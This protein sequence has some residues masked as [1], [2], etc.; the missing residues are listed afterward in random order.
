[1]NWADIGAT[2]GVAGVLVVFG[3]SCDAWVAKQEESG[4]AD[5]FTSLMVAFGVVVTLLMLAVLDLLWPTINAGVLG[6]GAFV[7]SGTPMLIGSV[8]LDVRLREKARAAMREIG[9]G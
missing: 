3:F 1:M 5:G 2:L 4:A 9:H 6:L 7:C 8:T